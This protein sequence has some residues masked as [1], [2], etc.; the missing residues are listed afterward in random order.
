VRAQAADGP[1]ADGAGGG[2][3]APDAARPLVLHVV[4]SLASGVASA[5]ED[6]VRSIPW[7]DHV[8]LG[9]RR[10]GA[11]T[12][13][14]LARLAAAVLPLP[15]G[16]LAQLREVRRRVEQ[17]RP[18][19]VHAHSSYA[20]LYVRLLPRR[21][22]PAV[23]YTPHGFSFER[24][25]VAAPVRAAF[26]LAEAALGLRGDVVAA[27]GPREAEL[28]RRLPGRRQVVY[29]PN[30]VRALEA[31]EPPPTP[32]PAANARRARPLRLATIGRIGPAKDPAFFRELVLLGR[33]LGLPLRWIWI[34]G[35]DAAAE[36]A[37]RDVGVLVTGWSSRRR[38]LGWLTTA[39][40]YVHTAA[41]EGAPVSV[42]EA[43]ALGLPVVARRNR[44][45]DALDLPVLC[46]TPRALVEAVAALLDPRRRE[47]LRDHS[48]RL[49]GRHHPDRQRRALRRA[50]SAALLRAAPRAARRLSADR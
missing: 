34:G 49:L 38:A 17:L 20:G 9:H 39:D 32:E 23:V 6:Y 22:T 7:C 43:A 31:V 45:L 16:R 14:G 12:G 42:L 2:D 15:A 50:Y 30:V 40:V 4:E 36:R 25:D 24:S 3:P 33:E 26:W 48:A 5:L 8:L 37:L 29:V 21:L 18:D 10:D 28:A 46:D 35:G 41:W 27:V 11:Q 13:D 19:L 1:R 44:A 47:E